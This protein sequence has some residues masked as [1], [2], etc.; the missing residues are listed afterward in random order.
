MN[1]RL[2][3]INDEDPVMGQAL[4][5]TTIDETT[6]VGTS[7]LTVTATDADMPNVSQVLL[8]IMDI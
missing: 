3:D 5:M 7:V 2:Q 1:I 6:P 4:Y 8:L